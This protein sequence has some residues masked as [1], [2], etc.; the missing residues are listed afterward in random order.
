MKSV[1]TWLL[2]LSHA[3]NYPRRLSDVVVCR[4][5]CP[6]H[7]ADRRHA[8]GRGAGWVGWRVARRRGHSQARGYGRLPPGHDRRGWTIRP[9]QPAGRRLRG[10]VGTQWFPSAPAHGDHT[11]RRRKRVDHTRPRAFHRGYG[12]HGHSRRVSGQHPNVRTELSR[13]PAH[14]RA[15]S[16]QRPQ[17]HGPDVAASRRHAL[18]APRQRVGRGPRPGHERQRTGSARQ[19]LPARRHVAQRFH[20]Q[21]RRVRRRHGARHGHGQGVP[22]RVQ[23]LPRGVWTQHRWP[24]QRHHQIRH[25]PTQRQCI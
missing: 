24:D 9:R 20:Q 3:P 25:Q 5:C 22:S 6:R 7:R 15:D 4:H 21:P 13:G 17:L 19:C 23:H 8:L 1:D 16:R 2:Y 18:P 14:D 12:G 11:H 10:A